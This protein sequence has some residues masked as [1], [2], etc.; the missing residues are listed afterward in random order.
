M[1]LL[2]DKRRKDDVGITLEFKNTTLAF[3]IKQVA[4]HIAVDL[5]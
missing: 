4:I 1:V 3:D 2:F 5:R